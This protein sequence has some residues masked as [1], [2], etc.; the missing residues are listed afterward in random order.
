MSKTKDKAESE[1]AV[2]PPPPKRTRGAGPGGDNETMKDKCAVVEHGTPLDLTLTKNSNH[3]GNSETQLSR[4]DTEKTAIL[5]S[6]TDTDTSAMDISI[7]SS[8]E[9]FMQISQQSIPRLDP[10]SEEESDS[11]E[12]ETSSVK[13]NLTQATTKDL[14]AEETLLKPNIDRFVVFPIKY[15]DIW[16]YYKKAQ[17][18]FWTVE[19]VDLGKDLPDWVK[20][21]EEE[22]RFISHVL[23]FFAASDGIVLENLVQRFSQEVQVAEA[24]CFYGF[25]IAMENVHSEMYSLLIDAY[26][27]EQEEKTRLFHA[28]DNM[29]CVKKKADW[30]IEWIQS[31]E[32]SFGERLVAFAA[33]EGIFF[34]GAFASIFW[35]KKR[36]LL[37]GL[38]FSNELISRDEGL[39]CDFACLIFS[40]LTYKPSKERIRNI[41]TQAVDIEKE[42]WNE[43]LP[44]GLIGMNVTLMNYYVEFVAD[45]LLL[46]LNCDKVY[47]R[48]N[49]FDFMENISLEGKTNFFEKRVGEY[50]KANVMSTV[51][52][53]QEFTLDAD[54]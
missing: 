16:K 53:R 31:E 52:Q 39:H 27:K 35:F 30:A 2:H 25:Q 38:T 40:H 8:Q 50:Q 46:E 49:P 41:I 21:K 47:H 28:I 1:H 44:V 15:Q 51:N 5:L 26:I 10:S 36:G 13:I 18:S 34:S 54:F 29:P 7:L 6:R 14:E 43:A 9:S 42:F 22:R 12:S 20:L 19:E 32:S 4:T 37:P 17:A 3:G 45:R 23:A 11:E 24:R 48:E 33:V